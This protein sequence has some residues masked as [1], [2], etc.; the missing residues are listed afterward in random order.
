MSAPACTYWLSFTAT[1]TT[2]PPTR[3]EICVMCPSICASSVDWRP[4]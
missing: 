3:A 4:E 1:F 2:V